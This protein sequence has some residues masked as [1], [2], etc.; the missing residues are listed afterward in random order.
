MGSSAKCLC[1]SMLTGL[2]A[3][4]QQAWADYL[5]QIGEG[6]TRGGQRGSDESVSI[7]PSMLATPNT[8]A[9]LISEIYGGLEHRHREASF[10][11]GR[12]ILA[13]RNVDVESINNKVL[14]MMPGQVSI[15]S[16]LDGLCGT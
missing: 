13:P 2:E 12:A 1:A 10:L 15:Y 11:T 5:M 9:G 6:R 16:G 14:D 7:R 8:I 4:A 3:A